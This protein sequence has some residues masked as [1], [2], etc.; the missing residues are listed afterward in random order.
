M[1]K[2][3]TGL[4]VT[5]F[6]LSM[7]S[8]GGDKVAEVTVDNAISGPMV[9]GSN[10]GKVTFDFTDEDGATYSCL[11]NGLKDGTNLSK[12]ELEE[13]A[14]NVGGHYAAGSIARIEGETYQPIDAEKYGGKDNK[15]SDKSMYGDANLCW[16]ASTADMLVGS[17]WASDEDE[18]FSLFTENFF[19]EGGYQNIGI[20]FY[21]SGINPDQ[22]P[23]EKEDEN[24]CRNAVFVE[25]EE[26]NLLGALQAR[27]PGGKDGKLVNAGVLNDYVAENLY[28]VKNAEGKDMDEIEQR[29]VEALDAGNAVGL[30]MVFYKGDSRVGVHAITATGYVKDSEGTLKGLIIS[31]SDNDID[32]GKEY[33]DS[34]ESTLA[35]RKAKPNSYTMYLT[36]AFQTNE[37]ELL[38]LKD[39]EFSNPKLKYDNAV[40]QQVTVLKSKALSTDADLEK[41]GT[42]DAANT[43]DIIL[44][45]AALTGENTNLQAK[46]GE[47]VTIPFVPS[48]ISYKGFASG[49]K[50]VVKCL[51]LIYEGDKQVGQKDADIKLVG[52]SYT[53]GEANCKFMGSL[54][55]SF[56]TAGEYRIDFKVVGIS[57][58]KGAIKEAYTGNNYLKAAATVTVK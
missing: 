36:D 47:E 30:G 24:G 10:L 45:D 29:I 55:H 56:D 39:Y 12:D 17:G 5:I 51:M 53:T 4:L 54:K 46:V 58:S 27:N 44:G 23:A 6:V 31:D 49:E 2:I 20:K 25:K 40:I 57:G 41:G 18:V 3:L 48:N 11:V 14:S 33:G 28:T 34:A 1:K 15:N 22:S 35:D 21:F 50:A 19:D 26:E 13:I 37:K 16:A 9:E 52:D 38:E 43:V 42:K 7:T 8:C 32:L